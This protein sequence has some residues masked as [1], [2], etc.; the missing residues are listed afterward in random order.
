[1]TDPRPNLFLIGAMKSG[2]SYLRRLLGSHPSI[3]M[4]DPDEPSYFVDP[5]QL[6]VIWP[7]MWHLG[8]WRSE[9]NYL[10]LFEQAVAAKIVGEA[11]TNYTKTPLLSGVA[12]RI[13]AFNPNARLIYLLRDPIERTIS[14]YWHMVRHHGENRPLIQ[15]VRRDAQFMDVSHY[16]MQLAPYLEYFPRERIAVLT[17]EE[18]VRNPTSTMRSLYEW[19]GVDPT[20]VDMSGFGEPE[21]VTPDLVSVRKYGALSRQLLQRLPLGGITPH[22]PQPLRLTLRR[23]STREVCRRSI[24]STELINFLRPIQVRQTERLANMLGRAFPEWTTLYEPAQRRQR[25]TELCD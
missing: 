15:A 24:D 10:K 25:A 12:K 18:L 1:M 22:I 14:H 19:L 6:R 16:A 11:S 3:F 9:A 2:T 4:C 17:H 8:F 23:L 7:D 20:A 5:K 13:Q 21:N